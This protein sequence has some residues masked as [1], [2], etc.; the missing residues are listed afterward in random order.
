M[1]ALGLGMTLR[2][3]WLRRI[4]QGLFWLLV[5]GVILGGVVRVSTL[6]SEAYATAEQFVRRNRCLKTVVGEVQSVRLAFFDHSEVK[7]GAIS[8]EA[9]L[10]VRVRGARSSARVAL[11]LVKDLGEWS[12]TSAIAK[13]NDRDSPNDLTKC[14]S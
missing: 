1:G 2:R 7:T 6:R 5:L 12:V 9:E 10:T 13:D 4:V 14:H 3:P 8:G 11:R